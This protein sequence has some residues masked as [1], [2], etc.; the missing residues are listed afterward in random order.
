MGLLV[1]TAAMIWSSSAISIV[2]HPRAQGVKAHSLDVFALSHTLEVILANEKLQLQSHGLP[3]LHCFRHDSAA[4]PTSELR[5]GLEQDSHSRNL[6]ALALGIQEAGEGLALVAC[7]KVFVLQGRLAS[8]QASQSKQVQIVGE[9][10][11]GGVQ[12]AETGASGRTWKDLALLVGKQHLLLQVA[13]EAL[14]ARQKG[15]SSLE[16]LQKTRHQGKIGSFK[17]S[18]VQ[19]CKAKKRTKVS[20]KH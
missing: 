1:A 2:L 11:C 7:S 12:R 8:S 13:T 17:Y 10:H 18:S 5:N 20:V 4:G 16:L 9:G 19:Y 15:D 14:L 3:I 6:V